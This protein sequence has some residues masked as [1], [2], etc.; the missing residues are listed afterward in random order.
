L[1]RPH[2]RLRL[3]AD[4]PVYTTSHIYEPATTANK[5][6]EGILFPDMPWMI[7][8]DEASN[9]LRTS[10]QKYW[11]TRARE[12]S[13][14]YAFGFDAYRLIPRLQPG[15]VNS[16]VTLAGLTGRLELES[17]GR[18]HRDLGW[19]RIVSGQPQPAE[20]VPTPEPPPVA[21]KP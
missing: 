8:P 9:Q 15:E 2:L 7:A 18:V 5:E 20:F 12:Q 1:L 21:D 19:A 13:R 6:L 14:L 3:P 17:N 16:N 11:P 10:L 4:M